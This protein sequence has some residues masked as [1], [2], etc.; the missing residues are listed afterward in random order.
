MIVDF[1]EN[2][3]FDE[4][5]VGQTASVT[6]LLTKRDIELFALLSGDLNP[7]H[8]DEGYAAE[9]D[10]RRQLAAHSLWGASLIS[11]VLGTYLPGA[12][13]VHRSQQLDFLR[14]VRVGDTLRVTVRAL[15]KQPADRTVTFECVGI[16]QNE[17]RVFEGTAR[18]V[19]PA[20]KVHRRRVDLPE[21]HFHEHGARYKN[22]IE[23][24]HQYPPV[25]TAVVHPVDAASLEG[26]ISAATAGLIEPLLV[27]PRAKILEAARIAGLDP[28]NYP[29]VDAPHS[30]AAAARGVELVRGGEA[31]ILMKGSLHTD[32]LMSE[33]V[34]GATGLRT[35]RR[36]S[37]AF[38]M[39]VPTY[40]KLLMITDAAINIYPDLLSKGDIVQN[41]IE[42]AQ[43]MGVER[44]KVAILSAVE[45]VTPKLQATMDAAALCKMADR[46]QITGGLLDGPLAF[47][48]AISRQAARTK[49]IRSEVAGDADILLVP[50]LEAGNMIA[51]QL[52]YLAE[53][54]TAGLV[55]GARVPIVLTSRADG[56]LA[57]MTSCALAVLYA[58]RK[59]KP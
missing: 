11:G 48:N 59:R 45:T 40:P 46:G 30:H 16:N 24:A 49:G 58:N 18:V 44:P 13:T 43:A 17:E 55:L 15:S 57:R 6:R 20:S 54:E 32:E 47:D 53:A 14:P 23:M 51:K 8:L 29:I 4:I 52:Q 7:T 21:V 27:G 38:V 5:A 19:A 31:G 28:G 50:D 3:T 9:R 56:A 35:E 39:E 37:H 33:V 26:A 36:V 41:A 22:L 10:G 34:R 12:G 25:R 1:V 42:L 2:Y